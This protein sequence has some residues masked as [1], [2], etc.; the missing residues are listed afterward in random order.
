MNR[1]L[2]ADLAVALC[3]VAMCAAGAALIS[4]WWLW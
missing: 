2:I 3:Y 1:H 4:A